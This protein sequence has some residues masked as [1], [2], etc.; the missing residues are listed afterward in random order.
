M[1]NTSANQTKPFTIY[2]NVNSH[3][4]LPELTG[5][6]IAD[7]LSNSYFTALP[8]FSPLVQNIVD[9]AK[10]NKIAILNNGVLNTRETDMTKFYGCGDA[11]QSWKNLYYVSSYYISDVTRQKM[12]FNLNKPFFEAF[13][14][15]NEPQYVMFH[16]NSTLSNGQKVQKFN[17]ITMNYA[18]SYKPQITYEQF[19]TNQLDMSKIPESSLSQAYQKFPK[20]I[21]EPATNKISQSNLIP[22]NTNIYLLNNS[23]NIILENNQGQEV[24]LNDSQNHLGMDK[25]GNFVFSKGLHPILKSRI[26]DAY[27]NLI[28]KNFFT[29]IDAKGSD[30]KLLP[31]IDRS[32]AIIRTAINNLINWYSL[33]SLTSPGQSVVMQNFFMP[34]GVF[35]T[36]IASNDQN[37]RWKYWNIAAYKPG[38]ENV[39]LGDSHG[40]VGSV[41]MNATNKW[42]KTTI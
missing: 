32:S 7:I 29:P 33:D 18:G 20:S 31:A 24:N 17:R 27:A 25:Y 42:L 41:N 15:D 19:I 3:D 38:E 21:Y 2:F 14:S 13:N 10:F 23:Q 11:Y 34:Y 39:P 35:N 26:S 36:K 8:S 16:L 6:N 37:P 12:V 9:N 4:H 22:Y 30:G 1:L 40:R 5:R 28:V